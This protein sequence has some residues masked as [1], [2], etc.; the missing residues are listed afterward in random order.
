M[1]SERHHRFENTINIDLKGV[2]IDILDVLD[3]YTGVHEQI[4]IQCDDQKVEIIATVQPN[5][6]RE[7]KVYRNG[8][9]VKHTF[10]S[11]VVYEKKDSNKDMKT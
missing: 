1:S 5:G 3:C 6:Q 10:G 7:V 9:L 8:R 11:T 4:R 2:L